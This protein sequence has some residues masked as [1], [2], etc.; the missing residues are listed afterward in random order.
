MKLAQLL[1]TLSL[2]AFALVGASVLNAQAADLSAKAQAGQASATSAVAADAGLPDLAWA[3][4]SQQPAGTVFFFEGDVPKQLAVR[5]ANGDLLTPAQT[6][7]SLSLDR[8]SFKDGVY[9][10]ESVAKGATG[11]QS[12]R[13]A[14]NPYESLVFN[15]PTTFHKNDA[16]PQNFR[17]WFHLKNPLPGQYFKVTYFKG[18]Q[19]VK[20]FRI[21]ADFSGWR[22]VSVPFRDMTDSYN[23]ES[24][25][26]ES[27]T[28]V[29]L[30]HGLEKVKRLVVP[31]GFVFDRFE[32]QAPNVQGEVNL[33]TV[34]GSFFVDNRHPVPSYQANFVNLDSQY[35]INKNWNGL[36]TYDQHLQKAF[37]NLSQVFAAKAQALKDNPVKAA[38][39]DAKVAGAQVGASGAFGE[40]SLKSAQIYKNVDYA[41]GVTQKLEL[42]TEQNPHPVSDLEGLKAQVDKALADFANLHLRQEGNEV[43]GPHLTFPTYLEQY[44]DSLNFT[45][46]NAEAY[47]TQGNDLRKIGQLLERTAKLL[48]TD[49]LSPEQRQVLSDKFV[50]AF[51]YVLDQGFAPGASY[52]LIHH[53]NYQT[54]E[55]FSALFI[56]RDLLAERGLLEKASHTLSYFN[57]TGRIFEP[58]VDAN[59]DILNTQLQWMLF[60]ILL[61]PDDATQ[62]KLLGKFSSWLSETLLASNGLSGGFKVDNTVFHHGQHYVPYAI[63]SLR[64]LSPTAFML[65]GSQYALSAPAQAK[66]A[67][68]L[69]AVD[70]YDKGVNIPI[71][72][73]GRHPT[74]RFKLS[75]DAFKWG[76]LAGAQ[77]GQVDP[78]L[79]GIY[80]RLTGKPLAENAPA[81]NEQVGTRAYNYATMLVARPASADKPENSWLLLARGFSRYFVGNE[82]YAA[83]N[84]YSRHS[85]YGRLELIPGDFEKRPYRHDGFDWRHWEGTTAPAVDFPQLKSVLLQLPSAGEEEMLL[86]DQTFAGAVTLDDQTGLFSQ[87][88]HGHS[89]YQE[90]NFWVNK[91]YF[92]FG[93]RVVALGTNLNHDSDKW[94]VHTTLTQAFQPNLDT[95]L[96]LNGTAVAN[97]SQVE[98]DGSVTPV[99]SLFNPTANVLYLVPG[100]QK[101]VVKNSEQVTPDDRNDKETKNRFTLAYLD[102]G[103]APKDATYEYSLVLDPKAQDA[104]GGFAYKV[105][106]NDKVAQVVYDEQTKTY[107]YALFGYT[108]AKAKQVNKVEQANA[109]VAQVAGQPLVGADQPALVLARPEGK[110]VH[111]AVVNPDVNLYQGV[112]ADQVDEKGL[113]KEVSVYS[114]KW[115]LSPSQATTTTYVLNGEYALVGE[116]VTVNSANKA[117]VSLKVEGGKTYVTVQVADAAQVKFTVEQK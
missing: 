45:K 81:T 87:V 74:E 65:S 91:S 93:N 21:N 49:S 100:K 8:S 42:A 94:P 44:R 6:R 79:G 82:A 3:S 80:A 47:R 11:G 46:D 50:Q 63:D 102:H 96:V 25:Y 103:L 113:Q 18:D 72:L 54:R 27:A 85:L 12:L 117:E 77:P 70:F 1:S 61:I 95:K 14:F 112:E 22:G 90:Q 69:K 28:R 5:A 104:T 60:S 40:A 13:W 101:L 114:R 20:E 55:L 66:F 67:A 83:N 33:D 115:F 88:V 32:V 48:R 51:N 53:V 41:L 78:A 92:V 111:L 24:A 31:E 116:P 89:K 19:A 57:G 105:L 107:A 68:V 26:G 84:R 86:S 56:A 7:L 99:T 4:V 62:E 38:A 29:E 39:G 36:F 52:Q 15:V 110:Q 109:Q 75:P 2:S 58:V 37:P 34:A 17:A 43:V 76:A 73:A 71:T 10:K 97:D 16:K 108:D 64:G 106:K 35:A 59:A 30:S 23:A 9:D 98:V